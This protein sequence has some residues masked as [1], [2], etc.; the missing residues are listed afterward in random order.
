MDTPV[1]NSWNADESTNVAGALSWQ[2]RRQP[3]ATAI[4]YPKSG[5]F[6]KEKYLSCSYQELDELSN[7]YARGLQEYGITRGTRSALMLTPGFITDGFGVLLLLPPTRAVV[8]TI[9]IHRFR[10]RVQVGSTL[11]GVVIGDIPSWR[12][13]HMP[14]GGVK[15][16]GLGREGIRF[17]M[18]DMTEIRLLVIR[19]P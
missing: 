1:E 5:A 3:N 18:E 6:G 10:D 8:R 9:L 16:S 4:H 15:E 13:D 17:A 2:A 14:Y 19:N 7:C 12:V 11:G